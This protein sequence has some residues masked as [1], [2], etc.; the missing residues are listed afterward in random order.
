MKQVFSFLLITLC[1]VFAYGRQGAIDTTTLNNWRIV[2]RGGINK[3][4]AYVHYLLLNWHTG[5]NRLFIPLSA[6]GF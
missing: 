4:G 2:K 3:N 6:T 5:S 1:A